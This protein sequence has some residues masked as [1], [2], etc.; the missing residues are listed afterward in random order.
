MAVGNLTFQCC[1]CPLHTCDPFG[2]V[3]FAIDA[4]CGVYLPIQTYGIKV[5]NSDPTTGNKNPLTGG[6]QLEHGSVFV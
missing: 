2:R 5:L 4:E 1:Y 3:L 6:V